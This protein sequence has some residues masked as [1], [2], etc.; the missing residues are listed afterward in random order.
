MGI[1]VDQPIKY[2]G[3]ARQIYIRGDLF[4]VQKDKG[5]QLYNEGVRLACRSTYRG[6]EENIC[7]T[8]T[9]AVLDNHSRYPDGESLKA[10]LL[11]KIQPLDEKSIGLTPFEGQEAILFGQ[12]LLQKVIAFEPLVIAAH[13]NFEAQKPQGCGETERT[14]EDGTLLCRFPKNIFGNQ[15]V[16]KISYDE[17]AQ[18]EREFDD[19]WRA[20]R[21]NH[22]NFDFSY[23]ADL[24]FMS[25]KERAVAG[26]REVKERIDKIIDDLNK[27]YVLYQ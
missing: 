18:A 21:R 19:F 7:V 16:F 23:G 12:E 26:I 11:A 24:K 9:R 8:N 1:R 14:G 13:D 25:S 22:G 5:H 6:D 2:N 15:D 10:A 3:R 4:E 20:D 17:V 27:V